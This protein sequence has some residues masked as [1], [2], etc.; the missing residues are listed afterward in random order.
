MIE[1]YMVE[2]PS[3]SYTKINFV[4]ISV[5]THRLLSDEPPPTGTQVISAAENLTIEDVSGLIK[6][7]TFSLWKAGGNI[8]KDMAEA[9]DRIRFAIVHR[10][11]SSTERHG[12][13]G[14]RSTR[15]GPSMHM[16]SAETTILLTFQRF[17]SFL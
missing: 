7:D 17:K 14:Q 11:S 3:R 16:V 1:N 8:S 13:L 4:P 12:E 2:K 6:P 5:D 9:L 15:M 10:F